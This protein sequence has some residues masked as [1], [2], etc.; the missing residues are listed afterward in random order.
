MTVP[1]ADMENSGV[2]GERRPYS[3]P[4]VEFLGT[5]GDMTL[6]TEGITT[7]EVSGSPG[8]SA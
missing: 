7:D 5:L 3:E 6:G 8:P 1:P 4:A 2:D